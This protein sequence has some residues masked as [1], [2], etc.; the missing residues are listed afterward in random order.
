M[1]QGGPLCTK[2]QSSKIASREINSNK[3]NSRKQ[4]VIKTY[5][6]NHSALYTCLDCILLRLEPVVS[7]QIARTLK[8][9][10]TF[11]WHLHYKGDFFQC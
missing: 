11:T 3:C 8:S 5:L 1:L 6:Y 9:L 2:E 4:L 7:P 10:A